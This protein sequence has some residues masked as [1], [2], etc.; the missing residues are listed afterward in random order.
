[1]VFVSVCASDRPNNSRHTIQNRPTEETFYVF[2]YIFT[3]RHSILIPLRL[4]E[5]SEHSGSESI[6]F[7]FLKI[8]S[9]KASKVVKTT[10]GPVSVCTRHR[11]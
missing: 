4:T 8:S 6:L 7:F 1:M 5:F 3:C 11:F 2:R 10:C 9:L